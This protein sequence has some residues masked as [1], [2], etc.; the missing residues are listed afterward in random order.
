MTA[1]TL[2]PL[3]QARNAPRDADE[4]IAALQATVKENEE[5]SRTYRAEVE[6]NEKQCQGIQRRID[7]AI[8]DSGSSSF[9]KVLQA[10]RVQAIKLQEQQFQCAVRD[11][12][13]EEQ[14][15]VIS[16]LWLVIEGVGLGRDDIEKVALQ[17]GT[18]LLGV[19]QRGIDHS[20]GPGSQ[21]W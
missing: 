19:D 6:D 17:Q 16:N 18:R 7:D 2:V 5:I 21:E 12:V 20:L 1:R 9:L 8:Q 11:Q 10:F 13:I 15:K 4:R 14:R 3:T